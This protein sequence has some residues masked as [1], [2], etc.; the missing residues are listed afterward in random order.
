MKRWM[1]LVVAT[2]M[3]VALLAGCGGGGGG[4][5]ELL[6]GGLAPLTG[7]VAVY[8]TSTRKGADLAFAEINE[9]GG[10]LGKQVKFEVLDEKG[11]P[12]EAVNAYNRL[13]S[14][15]I[16]ALLGDVTSKPTMA[17]AELAAKDGTPM[18][19]ATAS[20]VDVTSYGDNIF[21][22]CFTDPFQ[23]EVMAVFA[24]DSLNAKTAAIIY[25]TSDDYS[26][27]L[28]ESFQATAESKG[29]TIVAN[30]GYGAD[31]KDFKA[32]LTKIQSQNPD[33]VF[34]PEYYNKDAL[35]ASQAREI[36]ITAPLLGADGWDGVIGSMSEGN[37]DALN[38]CYFSNHYSVEDTDPKVVSFLEN[39]KETYN[40]DANAFAALGYDAAY[41]LAAAIEK[42]GSTDQEAIVKALSETDYAGVTGHISYAGSGDPIKSVSV[43]RIV[44]GKYTLY[45]KVTAGE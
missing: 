43:T 13:I 1:G 6:I 31:D 22:V 37:M 36:G 26:Q 44:D 24:A 8:G 2:L 35:I 27:G 10:V 38:D 9:N 20:H 3:M 34:V 30:E 5:D 19:S 41:I 11:D 39:Y 25:N 28:A 14:S 21:R 4:A 17:V 18:L 42:A 16:V 40:E 12:A 29:I 45:E 15:K 23:G 33:V 32:Q 7:D